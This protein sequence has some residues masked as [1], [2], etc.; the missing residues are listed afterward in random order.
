MGSN[1]QG[2]AAAWWP[3]RKVYRLHGPRSVLPPNNA[4]FEAKDVGTNSLTAVPVSRFGVLSDVSIP[5][6]CISHTLEPFHF[7]GKEDKDCPQ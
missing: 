3:S 6:S 5:S 7:G 1:Q 4:V 2:A